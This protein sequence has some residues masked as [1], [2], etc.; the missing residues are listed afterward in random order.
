MYAGRV[1]ILLGSVPVR[2]YSRHGF[3]TPPGLI[4]HAMLT[5]RLPL[6]SL[7]QLEEVYCTVGIITMH[8][9]TPATGSLQCRTNRLKEPRSSIYF[10]EYTK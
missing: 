7:F 4:F 8:T 6:H 3:G 9:A 2:L 1:E 5:V 10:L